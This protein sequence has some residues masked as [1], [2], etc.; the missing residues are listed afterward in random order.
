MIANHYKRIWPENR[1]LQA[2]LLY[3]KKVLIF[4]VVTS[5][6]LVFYATDVES[7]I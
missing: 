7:K 6:L 3:E 5:V 2:I 4:Y 1:Y